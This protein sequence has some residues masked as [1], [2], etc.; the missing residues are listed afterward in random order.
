MYTVEDF[1]KLKSSWA[2]DHVFPIVADYE[3]IFKEHEYHMT[4]FLMLNDQEKD[5]I[6]KNSEDMHQALFFYFLEWNGEA[7]IHGNVIYPSDLIVGAVLYCFLE[8]FD[9]VYGRKTYFPETERELKVSD[10]LIIVDRRKKYVPDPVVLYAKEC[11][12]HQPNITIFDEPALDP[13]KRR[14]MRLLAKFIGIQGRRIWTLYYPYDSHHIS[15]WK[16]L[17]IS[18]TE[19]LNT[20]KL[21]IP[22]ID[23]LPLGSWTRSRGNLF[24]P[25]GDWRREFLKTSDPCYFEEDIIR[26]KVA[27]PKAYLEMIRNKKD[28]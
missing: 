25:S 3:K 1:R 10:Y 27:L 11:K 2:P 7:I 26:T 12:Y 23:T 14:E 8:L 24:D 19:R 22:P 21:R 18:A 28:E 6:A 17:F 4:E 15:D 5:K 20:A 16:S 13:E 9:V